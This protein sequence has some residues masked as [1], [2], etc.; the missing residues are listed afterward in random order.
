MKLL[1]QKKAQELKQS[2]KELEAFRRIQATRLK[3]EEEKKLEAIGESYDQKKKQAKEEFEAFVKEHSF[4]KSELLAEIRQLEHD[5]DTAMEPYYAIKLEA[6]ELLETAKILNERAKKD[7]EKLDEEK[8]RIA[9]L[10]DELLEK[11]DELEKREGAITLKE[12]DLIR[13]D[14]KLLVEEKDLADRTKGFNAYCLEKESEIEGRLKEVERREVSMDA[15]KEI[16]FKEKD[17]VSKEW[18]RIK[19]QRESLQKGFDE[20][21]RKTT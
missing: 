21:R 9:E 11:K 5:R 18:I 7:S 8:E 10:N 14:S 12:Y 6:V 1:P 13:R 3:V 4:K 20:L 17:E 2:E 15:Q 19:D 16:L